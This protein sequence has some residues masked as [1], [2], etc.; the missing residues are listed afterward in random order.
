MTTSSRA[1]PTLAAV[2]AAA[3]LALWFAPR[4]WL[5]WQPRHA[6]DQPWRLWSAAFVHWSG[7]H[8]AANLLGCAVVAAFGVAA[9]VPRAAAVAWLLAWPLT[10]AALVLQ[11]QLLSYG[12]LSGVLH[13]G[14]AIAAL[15]LVWRA[16]ASRRAIGWAVLAGLTLKLLLEKPWPGPTL[17]P[18]GW[19]IRIAPLAHVTGTVAGLLCG[20]VAQWLPTGFRSPQGD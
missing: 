2:L 17:T 9:G 18:P 12:G 13:A 19:D 1:W 10:H 15:H 14:V 7:Q 6:L 4:E 20:A 8:L 11:P 5:D 3:A 16:Q